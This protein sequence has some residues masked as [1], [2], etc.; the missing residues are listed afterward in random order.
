MNILEFIPKGKIWQGKNTIAF[1]KTIE[2][3]LKRIQSEASTLFIECFP[4]TSQKLFED[5]KRL[6]QAQTIEGVISTLAATGGNTNDFF[7]S[8]ARKFDKDCFISIDDTSKQFIAGRAFAGQE[9]GTASIA[10]YF[11]IFQFSVP[12][13]IVEAEKILNKLKPA[14]L[15]FV[16]KYS[17]NKLNYMTRKED[18]M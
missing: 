2:I 4:Q 11:V 1:F 18:V 9:L 13:K 15:R 16:Y 5:W 10:Q 7:E 6:T 14:H 8:I 17:E 3:G 12:K